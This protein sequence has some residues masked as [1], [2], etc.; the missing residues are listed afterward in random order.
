[1]PTRASLANL[2]PR[3]RLKGCRDRFSRDLKIAIIDAASAYGSDG[4]SAGGLTGYLFHLASRH[5]KAFAHLLGKMLPY[6]LNGTMQ[7][8]IEQVNIVS[9][10]SDR[11]LRSEDL[12]RMMPPLQIEAEVESEPDLPEPPASTH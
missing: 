5:P 7:S 1:M 12:R 9:I 6:Q 10:P 8:V 3:P 11:Y 2:K 4:N